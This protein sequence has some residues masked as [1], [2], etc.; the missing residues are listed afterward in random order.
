MIDFAATTPSDQTFRWE[1]FFGMSRDHRAIVETLRDIVNAANLTH[2]LTIAERATLVATASRQPSH[3][4]VSPVHRLQV[5]ALT[6]STRFVSAF[7]SLLRRASETAQ[8]QPSC[9][10]SQP[11]GSQRRSCVTAGVPMPHPRH[12]RRETQQSHC[13]RWRW[14]SEFQ[15]TF[16]PFLPVTASAS[17]SKRSMSC[18]I[19]KR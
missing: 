2:A 4:P 15:T 9:W 19:R 6:Q 1:D 11:Q 7:H 17:C 13:S 10:K 5:F 12:H 8:R 18:S 14:S 16:T 3:A